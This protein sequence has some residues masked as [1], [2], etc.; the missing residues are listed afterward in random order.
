MTCAF[1]FQELA[2]RNTFINDLDELGYHIDFVCGY[3]VIYGLPYLDK[4]KALRY[5]DWISPV[6][7]NADGLIGPPTSHQA[8]FNGE[9]PYNQSGGELKVGFAE[10]PIEVTK[11]LAAKYSF[12]LKLQD[13]AGQAR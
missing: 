10:N 2:S 8:W 11:G 6:D 7:L 9:R 4:D 12:S 13:Q 1:G 3:L 5:A